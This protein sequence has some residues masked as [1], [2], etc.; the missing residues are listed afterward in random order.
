MTISS[1]TAFSY[2]PRW[3]QHRRRTAYCSLTLLNEYQLLIQQAHYMP[4][5]RINDY[6]QVKYG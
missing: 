4:A 5:T 1:D 3:L 2:I 6:C